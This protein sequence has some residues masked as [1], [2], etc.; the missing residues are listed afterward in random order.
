MSQTLKTFKSMFN[1][2]FT[3]IPLSGIK[4]ISCIAEKNILD[5]LQLIKSES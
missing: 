4:R 1:D 3:F 5:K 2:C